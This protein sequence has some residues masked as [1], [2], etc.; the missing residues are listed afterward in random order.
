MS[1]KIL[2]IIGTKPRRILWVAKALGIR[3]SE[4]MPAIDEWNRKQKSWL[5]DNSMSY[6]VFGNGRNMRV[7][8]KPGHMTIAGRY[9][10]KKP[11]AMRK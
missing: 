6:D 8:V 10:F 3:E 11:K 4:V 1:R 5:D 7:R 2:G 9:G